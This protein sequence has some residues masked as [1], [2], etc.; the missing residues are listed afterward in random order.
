M[1]KPVNV[2][3]SRE[4]YSDPDTVVNYD[5]QRF[6]STRDQMRYRLQLTLLTEMLPPPPGKLLEIGCGTGILTEKMSHR[7]YKVIAIDPSLSMLNKCQERLAGSKQLVHL[8]QAS[9]AMVPFDIGYADASFC[10][11]VLSHIPEP[12]QIVS[13]MVR[14]TRSGGSIVFNFTNLSSPV[15][16]LIHYLINPLRRLKKIQRVHT[17]YHS[18]SWLLDQCKELPVKIERVTGLFPLDWRIYPKNLSPAWIDRF[19]ALEHSM[20]R[21]DRV[22][23]FQ[24]AWV[25]LRKHPHLKAN[26]N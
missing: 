16:K 6:A 26:K 15:G 2:R 21:W 11:N 10:V 12:M 25:H 23:L 1:R 17:S 24:Q 7:G 14:I 8:L 18:A 22:C 4:F 9:G 5:A 3:K 19:E 20:S 13:E